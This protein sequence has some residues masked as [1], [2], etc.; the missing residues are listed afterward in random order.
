[1]LRHLKENDAADRMQR[2]I[3]RVYANGQQ[4]PRDVGGKASTAEFTDAVI[5]QLNAN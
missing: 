4:L 1:M 5:R 3:E 2:A